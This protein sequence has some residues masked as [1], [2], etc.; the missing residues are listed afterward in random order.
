MAVYNGDRVNWVEQ[1]VNSILQ[2]TLDAFVFVIVIDGTILA[3]LM[4]LLLAFSERDSRIVLLQNETNI[5]LA[6]SMN[7]AIEWG[8][9]ISPKYFVRMDADDVS[10]PERLE[11]QISYLQH[12]EHVAVLGSGLTEIDEEGN[13]VG[14][15]VMPASHKKIVRMLPRRCTLN[16]PTVTIRYDVFAQGFRYDADLLNTQDYFLWITLASHGFVFRNLKERLLEFRRVN[17][18]YKRRGFAK[19]VNE[20]KARIY[21]MKALRRFTLWNVTYACG[22][23]CLRL[24]PA[25][26]VKLAYKFDRLLLEKIIKH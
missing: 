25:K 15:R 4:E 3:E 7:K 8:F 1:A 21:A 26:V 18:F 20:F 24:M 16:H 10:K 14:A 13:K 19:S 5:G 6:A 22:V 11:R 17:D 12:H 23:L 9:C 2:Q